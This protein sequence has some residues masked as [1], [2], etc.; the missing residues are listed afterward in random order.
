MPE[1][2]QISSVQFAT[3]ILLDLQ[4]IQP[5]CGEPVAAIYA[6]NLLR[7]MQAMRDQFPY[8]PL[9]E[10]VMA[11]HDAIAFQNRWID[12]TSSQYKGAHDL[13]TTLLTS[14]LSNDDSVVDAA[15]GEYVEQAIL[16]LEDLGF[17]ILPFGVELNSSIDRDEDED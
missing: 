2:Q 9:T 3:Q 15:A 16:A 17:D 12:Y 14:Q 10:F 4:K 1:V 6:D 13:L 5:Y 7:T 8:E 11:L